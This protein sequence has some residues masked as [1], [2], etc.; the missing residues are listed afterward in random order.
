MCSVEAAT[1]VKSPLLS[2]YHI[3]TFWPGVVE[4]AK[5]HE[6]LSHFLSG[7]NNGAESKAGTWVSLP[8]PPVWDPW[9]FIIAANLLR[10]QYWESY[11]FTT[12]AIL[13]LFGG[14]YALYSFLHKILSWAKSINDHL[15]THYNFPIPFLQKGANV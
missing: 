1:C 2:W 14:H 12:D 13:N 15:N 6:R 10:G 5:A 9:Q 3:T 4:G 8:K 11:Y 7:F